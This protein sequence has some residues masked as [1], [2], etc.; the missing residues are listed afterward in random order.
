VAAWLGLGAAV[1]HALE[2]GVDR[3]EVTVAARAE[4]LRSM[5]VDA[6][7]TVYDEGLER[8]GIV[9]TA[10]ATEPSALLQARLAEHRVNATTTTTTSARWDVDRRNLPVLLRLSVHYTTTENELERAVEVL[11]RGR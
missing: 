7:F 6:G 2:W 4:Q 9:T 11:V 8:C 3:I 10:S 1:D 5:L